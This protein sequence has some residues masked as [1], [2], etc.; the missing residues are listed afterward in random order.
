MNSPDIV[1]RIDRK[2]LLFVGALVLVVAVG[3]RL[4]AEVL[5]LATTYPAPSGIYNQLVT[6]GNSG[7][8]AADTTF[9]RNAGNT[10][11]I[12]ATNAGG[13]VGIGTAAPRASIGGVNVS[14]RSLGRFSRVMSMLVPA[15]PIAID[16]VP[17]A[18]FSG[19]LYGGSPGVYQ[20]VAGVSVVTEGH[21]SGWRLA[22]DGSGMFRGGVRASRVEAGTGGITL[23]GVNRASW[24]GIIAANFITRS[25]PP[26][27]VRVDCLAGEVMI[28]GGCRGD[29]LCNGNDSS[30]YGDWPSGNGWECQQIRC[31]RTT[32]YVRCYRPQ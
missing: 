23:G 5:T 14:Y 18:A 9:N 26:G 27:S 8:L 12:P 2:A 21:P 7:T 32:P 16:V 25:G 31:T 20:Y 6:T 4:W 19:T 29:D 30:A 3:P 10:I 1:F 13:R 11:L 24:P 28:S 15:V 22:G 17:N